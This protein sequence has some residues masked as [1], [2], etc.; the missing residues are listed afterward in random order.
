MIS[1]TLELLN[2]FVLFKFILGYDFQKTRIPIAIGIILITMD[3]AIRLVF[4]NSTTYEINCLFTA[5][6]IIIPLCF[7]NGRFFVVLGLSASIKAITELL[8]EIPYGLALIMINGNVEA[9]NGK[10]IA[11][12]LHVLMLIIYCTTTY[13]I[14]GKREQIHR[15]IET[16]PPLLFIP[17]FIAMFVFQINSYYSG[18]IDQNEA[19]IIHASN[20]VRNGLL[21]IFVL[22]ICILAIYLRSQKQELKH[23]VMLNKKC[24]AEQS[25]QYQFMNEKDKEIKKFRH[26]YNQHIIVLQSLSKKENFVGLRSYIDQLGAISIGL[27]FI[28]TNNII[29]DAI[30]NVYHELCSKSGI[31]LSVI[32]KFPED[33]KV[34]EVDL[35]SILSNGMENAYEATQIFE[36]KREINIKIKSHENLLFIEIENPTKE[37]PVIRK[38]FIET[39]KDDKN[40]HGY[41][42]VNMSEAALRNGG[43]VTWEYRSPG[44]LSTHI[45]LLLD[46]I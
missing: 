10:I 15:A 34:S 4:Y 33:M 36:G 40:H 35:C 39:L 23:Q 44:V 9:L 16:I 7:F 18:A 13:F 29:C 38:G 21:G 43:N 46:E 14:W 3:Y 28:S 45:V 12:I 30:V 6:M 2:I 19:Q 24:I 20:M 42:T 22:A 1:F 32:G 31:K 41:G 26:D 25:R 5:I 37:Q 17:F 8:Y 11:I 27:D